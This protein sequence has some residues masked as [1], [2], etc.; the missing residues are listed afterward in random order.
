LNPETL[1]DAAF[2][3]R[4]A[5]STADLRA[6]AALFGEYAQGLGV[7]LAYQDFAAEVATLPGKYAPPEGE[8][9][10]A[11]GVDGEALGCVGLRP[12]G[13]G[14]CEM[15]RLYVPP[16]A[17]RLGVGAALIAA[18]VA[19]A[20]A[21]GYREIWLDTLPQMTRAQSLYRQ[22]GFTPIAPYYDTPVEGTA[23]LGLTL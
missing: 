16:A 13:D 19:K 7:D 9:L 17:R 8:L 3:I 18:I 23:F 1:R 10:I 20:A 14:R 11:S 22:A 12:L 6:A 2:A 5:R 15:K 21:I 4:P